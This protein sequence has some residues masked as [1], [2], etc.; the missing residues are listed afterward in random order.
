MRHFARLAA[1]GWISGGCGAVPAVAP[2]PQPQA[3][4]ESPVL[5]AAPDTADPAPAADP[6]STLAT[7]AAEPVAPCLPEMV[8]VAQR[9][10]IDRYE[11]TMVDKTTRRP[12]SPFF[13]PSRKEVRRA[14]AGQKWGPA[15]LGKEELEPPVPLLPEWERN[16]DVEALAVSAAH[17]TPQAYLS[18]PTAKAACEAAGKRLCHLTEWK[19]ACRGDQNTRYPYGDKY[20]IGVCNV[21]GTSHPASI[22]YGNASL[23]HWDPRLN[24]VTVDGALLL[25]QTGETPKCRSAWGADGVYDMVGNLDEWV[26]DDKS[27]F[28]GGFYARDTFRGCDARVSK[29]PPIFFDFTTGVRC[30]ADRRDG[31]STD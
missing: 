3:P 18:K 5:A 20:R 8:F 6:P 27:T 7:A 22:L 17:V 10:C 9:F 31:K 2:D 4:V 29:H 26:E 30:C 12:F 28:V 1:L 19:L 14:I 11:A 15:A 13:P 25:H 23:G 21:H 16:P 24:Q